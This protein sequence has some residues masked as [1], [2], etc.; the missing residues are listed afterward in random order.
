MSPVTTFLRKY[1]TWLL[2]VLIYSIWRLCIFIYQVYF[3]HQIV[4]DTQFAETLWQKTIY[5]F[6]RYWDANFYFH[7]AQ[8]GYTEL[9]H[10]NFF[11]VFPIV[12]SLLFKLFPNTYLTSFI[13]HYLNGQLIS[14]LFVKTSLQFTKHP[15]TNLL[16]FLTFPGTFFI[17]ANYAEGLLITF[18]L[19]AIL[20]VQQ[21]QYFLA[22]IFIGLASGTKLVG[23]FS[24]FFLLFSPLTIKHK[25]IYTPIGLSGL[26]SYIFFLYTNFGDPLLFLAAQ[27][28]WCK[29]VE[30]C[31][32]TFPFLTPFHWLYRLLTTPSLYSTLYLDFIYLVFLF[33][34]CFR[35]YKK[36]PTK[37]LLFSISVILPWL[38]TGKISSITRYSIIAIPIF[39]AITLTIPNQKAQQAIIICHFFVQLILIG[40]FSNHIWVG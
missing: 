13:F 21:K 10:Y 3:Q 39:L 11:P 6:S 40:L 1:Q 37:Y 28:E 18:L 2:P 36:I 27:N 22:S 14:I 34:L 20:L 29:T 26:L 15:Y 24:I 8:N 9:S 19:S 16:I 30:T 7:I 38:S 17:F 4:A 33:A 25:L 31:H 32:P 23:A 12:L 5:S 35:L